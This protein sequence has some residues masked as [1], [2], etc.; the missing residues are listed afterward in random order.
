LKRGK[1]AKS[2]DGSEA[3]TSSQRPEI[4]QIE[5]L[6]YVL[7]QANSKLPAERLLDILR[8]SPSGLTAK[9]VAERLGATATHIGS[10]LSKLAA[11]GVIDKKRGR[12]A[13]N[14]SPCAVYNFP[15]P[16]INVASYPPE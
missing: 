12:I 1:G 5:G 3:R 9:E 4:A 15:I 2:R 8:D 16:L 7:P 13:P 11:Y 6:G 14:V 10:R